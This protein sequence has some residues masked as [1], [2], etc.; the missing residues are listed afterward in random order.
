MFRLALLSSLTLL[1]A[2]L[3]LAQEA[4]T[5]GRGVEMVQVTPALTDEVLLNPRMGLYLQYPPLTAKPEDWFMKIAGVAYYRMDWSEL[6]PEEGVYKFDEYFGPRF[7]FWV[8]QVAS[9]SPASG[10]VPGMHAIAD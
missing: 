3:A 1:I 4:P 8:V 6:N 5:P 2:A 10:H 7:D 9:A